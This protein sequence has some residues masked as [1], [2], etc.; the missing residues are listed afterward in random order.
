M[1][2]VLSSFQKVRRIPRNYLEKIIFLKT[3]FCASGCTNFDELTHQKLFPYKSGPRMGCASQGEDILMDQIT[4]FVMAVSQILNNNELNS[5]KSKL[6]AGLLNSQYA[7]KRLQANF[8]AAN[9]RCRISVFPI[10]CP[11]CSISLLHTMLIKI[12]TSN[13]CI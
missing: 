10:L 12:L 6:D 9:A 4:E 2:F 3:R 7:G 1:K 8:L 11:T 5:L 13:Y